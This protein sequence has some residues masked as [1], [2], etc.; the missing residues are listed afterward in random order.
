MYYELDK[1]KPI[2]EIINKLK[3]TVKGESVE[4]LS[5]KIMYDYHTGSCEGTYQNLQH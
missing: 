1:I 5:A 4:A 2:L 3:L